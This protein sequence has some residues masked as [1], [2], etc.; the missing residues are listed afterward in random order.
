MSKRYLTREDLKGKEVIDL[1]ATR[2]GTVKDI[3]LD[4]ETQKLFVAITKRVEAGVEEESYIPGDRIEK[5]RDVV[6][7]KAGQPK[8]S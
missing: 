5:I 2:V 7:V 8:P 6:L 4:V 3:V 1:D